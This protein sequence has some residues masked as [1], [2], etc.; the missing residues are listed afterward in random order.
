[1]AKIL[2]I[3]APLHGHVNPTLAI[4][5]G[6]VEA[7][8]EVTYLLTE[9]FRE[10]IEKTGA[11]FEAYKF[12]GK[13]YTSE[14]VGLKGDLK[15]MYDR[16][17]E[18]AKECDCL[19]Y[20]FIFMFGR[21][22][23]KKLNKPT[24]RLYSTF[25]LKKD[26]LVNMLSMSNGV[27]GKI[28]NKS[29]FRKIISKFMC[30]KLDIEIKD[31][32]D[33]I[34]CEDVELNI[35]FTSKEFQVENTRFDDTKW[36]FVGPLITERN[37]PYFIPLDQLKNKIIYISLGT[38]FNKSLKFFKNC[39][40]AFKDSD[41][42]VIMSIG[43]NVK[44]ENLGTIPDNFYVAEFV[45]QLEVLKRADL[46]ITHGGMN[47]GNEAIYYAVPT[48]I[49]PQSLDQYLVGERMEEFSL[50]KVINKKEVTPEKL[51]NFAKEILEHKDYKNNMIKMSEHMKDAGGAKRAV[52]L[53]EKYINDKNKNKKL[54]T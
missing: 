13:K 39:I 4:A 43:K 29:F 8:H 48:I 47:S 51:R 37:D 14:K 21:D 18:L 2:M 36:K 9:E 42:T 27:I 1:M 46:F 41:T 32:L 3:N 17:F 28:I 33:E 16:A 15:L 30:R 24:I 44:K 31:L 53:I 26:I 38:I 19:I 52:E 45:P 34:S 5:K 11:K 7:G 35:T 25:A 6:L 22:I 54:D 49:V 23:G 50:G 20:E 12:E 40:E 10:K